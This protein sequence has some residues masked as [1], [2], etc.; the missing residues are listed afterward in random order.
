V[1]FGPQWIGTKLN[2][3]SGAGEFTQ[4]VSV[5]RPGDYD[6]SFKDSKGYIGVKT[7]KVVAAAT[8]IPTSSPTTAPVTTRPLTTVPTTLPTTTQSPFS[9][10][11]IVAALSLVGLFSVTMMKKRL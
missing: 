9:P 3:Q 1:V 10:L 4:Q 11:P 7:F 8:P 6:V 2:I 5:T